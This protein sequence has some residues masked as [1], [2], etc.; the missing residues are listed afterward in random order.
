MT[1]A[2]PAPL[3]VPAEI[4]ELAGVVASPLRADL[5]MQRQFF[6][7]SEYYVIKDPLALTYFRLRH[8]EGFLIMLLD[9]KRT[10]REVLRLFHLRFP[11]KEFTSQD[12]A[13]FV[14]QMSSAGLLNVNARRFVSA[15]RAQ[16]SLK[17][18]W[19]MMWGKLISGLLFM[20]IPLLD[21][22][23]WLG[24][25]TH[26]LRFI[27]TRWFVGLCSAFILWSAFWLLVNR[28]AFG[29]NTVNFF[30]S[31]N[32]LLVWLTIIFVKTCHEFG[33][34]TT[35][36]HFGGE[37][38]EMGAALICFTPCG[39]VDA[40]DAWMMRKNS[41]KIYTT[42]AGVFTEF[43]IAG[44]AAHLWLYLP[45][46]L[47]KNLAFNAMVVASVNTVFFN[48]NPLM[49]FD[50]YYVLCDVLQIPNLRSKAMTFCS[51]HIQRWL[52]GYRNLIQE[53]QLDEEH[54][55]SVFIT[56][57]ILAYIYMM[58]V[59]Y[60]LTQVFGRVLAPYGLHDFGLAVGIFV[61][62]SFAMFPIVRVLSDAFAVGR[63][64]TIR[65]EKASVRVARWLVP[66]VVLGGIV[67][68][69]P[70]H[71]RV[72]QQAVLVAARSERAGVEFGGV[73]ERVQVRSGQ[74]VEAGQPLLTLRNADIDTDARAAEL[75]FEAAKLQLAVLEGD[76]S[77]RTTSLAPEA[78][79]SLESAST[80]L[81][82]ARRSQELLIVR[83]PTAGYVATPDITR[84]E[85][86]YLA[87]GFSG[88]RVAD[89]RRFKLMIPLS[90]AQAELV[91]EGSEV[92]GYT[93]ADGLPIKAR[94][95]VLPHQKA[96]WSD[97]QPAM[98]AA[99]GGPAP[100]E[101]QSAAA[102]TAPSFALFIAEA[103]VSVPPAGAAEG[104]RVH[105]TII[106][107]RAT[108]GERFWRWF[109][110]LWRPRPT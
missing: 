43:V 98:L 82:R 48:A 72:R 51:Y 58:T 105:V 7:G 40:S 32:L 104:L 99:F 34:A 36:R 52:L 50:G 90:E 64:N 110:G 49:K 87:A 30:S 18:G 78:A 19:L 88:L 22:S 44:I 20:R 103:D 29:Q 17:T 10:F 101:P 75:S 66:L 39:Y 53:R 79:L 92:R 86:E 37:V 25:L 14:N 27:W 23:P 81:D 38:H 69:V 13:T 107:K 93:R 65:E 1:T 77:L 102:R 24:G 97:Y 62:G 106:G 95:T 11:N 21:P 2:I 100:F 85:G 89:L 54:D 28:D 45:P 60:G 26:A 15:A 109:S 4:D 56:Y 47:P 94:L 61:E 5:E 108:Y 3:P 59:I 57:S 42:I 8:E 83:A 96:I 74:W 84:L 71:Y 31:D 70:G 6:R 12:L 33:H 55:S 41:Q 46:G 35:C 91:E 80:A 63:G 9:G 73:V 76:G 16:K 68:F 67:A